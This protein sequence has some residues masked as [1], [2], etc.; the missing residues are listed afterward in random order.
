VTVSKGATLTNE[1]QLDNKRGGDMTREEIVESR[2]LDSKEFLEWVLKRRVTDTPRG[3]FI[4]D[5]RSLWKSKKGDPYEIAA[6][7]YH[8]S[9]V[10]RAEGF[11]LARQ[12]LTEK[13]KEEA[14]DR[15]C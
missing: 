12:F 11:K 3:D 10:A 1:G 8:G 5:T 2:V 9:Q 13:G 15:V 6:A 14:A 7:F 4:N